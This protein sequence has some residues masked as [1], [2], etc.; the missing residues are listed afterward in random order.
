LILFK[1]IIEDHDIEKWVE[2]I[3]TCAL[4][5]G[6]LSIAYIV[7]YAYGSEL[8]PTSIRGTAFGVSVT[9]ARLV[10]LLSG[11]LIDLAKSWDLP[12]MTLCASTSLIGALALILLR[13]TY[14]VKLD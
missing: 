11:E 6:G 2:T 12:S 1:Y 4:I 8:F 13:E 10:G 7:V 14:N 9:I 5:K 3:V